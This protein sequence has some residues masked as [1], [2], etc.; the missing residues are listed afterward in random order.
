MFFPFHQ[1]F[2]N[3]WVS[4]LSLLNKK[5]LQIGVWLAAIALALGIAARFW[6]VTFPV[7]AVPF[8][9]TRAEVTGRMEKFLASMGAPVGEYRGALR[10]GEAAEARNFIERQ[11]GPASLATAAHDG[12]DLW[13]WTGRWFKAGQHEEYRASSDQ[14]GN[15]VGY[16]HIIEEER[17]L[18]SLTEAQARTVAENFLRAHISQHPFAALHYLETSTEQKPRRMDY[19]FVWEQDSLRMG[20]APYQLSV[21]VHGNEVGGYA[22][23]LKVPEWWLVQYAR[24]RS[25]NDFCYRLATF[26]TSCI[27]AGLVI[28]L[29]IGIRNHQVRWRDAVPWGW[30]ALIG[31]VAAATQIDSIPDI[32]FGYPTTQQWEPFVAGAVFDAVRSV[33]GQVLLFWALM[34]VA[35]CIYRECLTGKSSFRRALGPAALRDSQTVRALGVGIAFAVFS[36]AYVCLFYAAGR[37]LGVWCPV[38]VDLSRAMSGPM[39]WVQA[40]QTGFSASFN[41]EMI[42]RAGA[43]LLLWR[44]LRVRWAAVVLSAAA[45]GFM[46]SNYPQIPG[47]TRGI[48]LTIVGIVWGALML[49]YGIVAT[50]TAHYLYDCGIGSLAAFQAAGWENKAGAIAVTAWPLALFLWGTFRSQPELEPEQAR[51]PGKPSAAQPPVRE[52]AH[53]QLQL[54]PWGVALMLAAC[55]AALALIVLLPKPQDKFS[56]LGRLDISRTAILEK[57]DAALKDHGYA[58][59][60][61]ERVTETYVTGLP[62]EYLL[63][64]GS[65]DRLAE[66]YRSEFPDLYWLVRYFRFLQPEEFTVKLDAHGRFLTWDH[67]VLREG[68]GA[69]LGESQALAQAGKALEEDGGIDLSRQEIVLKNPVE[70]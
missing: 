61:Y 50:L 51:V 28:T 30:L 57:A 67:T 62:A 49:R 68:P 23:T 13:Y 63:E 4:I 26:A 65:L 9:L 15:I 39:P 41:E 46:H 29:L 14:E 31:A 53:V 11:Y 69:E 52:W 60:G 19:N 7:A 37:Q 25:V 21:A 35:D 38:E 66:L 64:H 43:I 3:E 56:T 20:E 16:S 33:L 34:L 59:D 10:F 48:E 2:P 40:M 70:Q 24:Q 6:S 8:P 12:V 58:P 22:E 18:P 36:F 1:R 17:A 42:F 27:V 44:I 47:Y 32:L 55:A 5:S 45:W 54:S